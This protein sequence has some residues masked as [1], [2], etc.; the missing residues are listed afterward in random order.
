[1]LKLTGSLILLFFHDVKTVSDIVSAWSGLKL[2]L[3]DLTGILLLA[4][5]GNR[6][7][8]ALGGRYSLHDW[9]RVIVADSRI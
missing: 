5:V 7:E 2:A 9:L 6:L 8:N 1:M 4:S 3:D